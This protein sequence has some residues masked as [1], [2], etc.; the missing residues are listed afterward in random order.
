MR[1]DTV[2]LPQALTLAA[3]RSEHHEGPDFMC[4]WFALGAAKNSAL[5]CP[6]LRRPAARAACTS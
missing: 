5:T 4:D 1:L 6:F 3:A 2:E